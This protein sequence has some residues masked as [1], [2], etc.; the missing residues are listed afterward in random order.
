MAT[1]SVF[2]INVED[3]QF[4]EFYKLF[5]EYQAHLGKMPDDWR[6]ID[7]MQKKAAR[8]VKDV[9]TGSTAQI[10]SMATFSKQMQESLHKAVI[11]QKNF[12]RETRGSAKELKTMAANAKSLSSSI[13]GIGKFLFKIGALGG[14]LSLLGGFGLR[15]LGEGAV[16][17]QA[18]ARTLGMSPGQLSAWNL[19]F[20]KR[21]IGINAVQSVFGEQMDASKWGSLLM[22]TQGTGISPNQAF[23][24]APDKLTYAIAQA[25]AR[26]WNRESASQRALDPFLKAQAGA[27][28]GDLGTVRMLAHAERHGEL[29]KAWSQYRKDSGAFN[30]SGQNTSAWYKFV[31]QISKLGT[32]IEVDL[33]NKLAALA[34]SLSELIKS[35]GTDGKKLID[36]VFSPKNIDAMRA[37]IGAFVNYLGSPEFKKDFAGFESDL[38]EFFKGVRALARAMG[39]IA[40]KLSDKNK[41]K[42]W[43]PM[44]TGS[45]A[46]MH[47]QNKAFLDSLARKQPS[48]AAR[49]SS[50]LIGGPPAVN[51]HAFV[52]SLE[53]RNGLPPGTL[54]GLYG[55]ESSYGKNEG[56]SSAKALGPF[57]WMKA[58][59]PE[60]GVTNRR[61]FGQSAQGAARYFKQ[62]LAKYKG[63]LSKAVASYNW[64]YGNLDKDIKAHGRDWLRYAPA[65]TRREVVRV[66]HVVIENKA[67]SNIA[68]STYAAA[69]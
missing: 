51:K 14:G 37:A 53:Q 8:S 55:A 62:A 46:Q 66:Q 29:S 56:Y 28:G 33:T 43:D 48:A 35:L 25:S 31:R 13:F 68:V 65:E 39:W 32:T 18:Q 20:G 26:R 34:P 24:M 52:S 12:H 45:A 17:R 58:S 47:A 50:G 42:P 7:Q 23:T 2:E 11:A 21:Y 36:D 41:G 16:R 5:Q 59:A 69:Q 27:M 61:D 15:E 30:V 3:S 22:A 10:G 44:L 49:T 57:Q 9:L 54:W 63:D 1:K 60:Y 19:D 40:E 67:G 38:K 6:K 64:G 4:K